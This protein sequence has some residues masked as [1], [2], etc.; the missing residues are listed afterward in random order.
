MPIDA[1]ILALL[2]CPESRQPLQ[3]ASQQVLDAVNARIGRGEQKNQ[4]GQL[5]TEPFTEALVRQDGT[6]AYP[7]RDDIPSLLISER[8]DLPPAGTPVGT[9]ATAG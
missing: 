9:Q 2:A 7:I 4:G 3:P 5:I 1:K 8:V 6:C